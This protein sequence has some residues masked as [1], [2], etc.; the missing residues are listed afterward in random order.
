MENGR[1]TF[2]YLGI[3]FQQVSAVTDE[4]VQRAASR[5]TCCKQRW[6][7][8]AINV[9]P[10]EVD[11]VCDGRPFR[12]IASYLSKVFNINLPHMRLEPPLEVTPF[13]FCLDLRHQKT[14]VLGYRVALFA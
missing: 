10:D 14:T 12:V 5:Q 4:P 3:V 13:E 7:I 1:F 9:R 2:E 6:T 8:S 11:N